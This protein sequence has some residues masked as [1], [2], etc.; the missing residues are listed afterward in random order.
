MAD[1][2][3]IADVG[4][5]LVQLLR[6]NMTPDPIPNPE[7]IGLASPADKGDLALSLFLYEVQQ[8]GIHQQN[9]WSDSGKSQQ[10]PPMA[11][12]LHF[13]LTAHSGADLQTRALDEHRILG[14]AIQVLYDNQT[15][16]GSWLQGALGDSDE[17]FRLVLMEP[18][19]LHTAIT[20][21]PNLPYKLS[22]NFIAG[23]IYLDSGRHKQ[24]QRVL[25]RK[26]SV[27]GL[28]GS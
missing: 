21:F 26:D 22:F 9:F 2:T 19:S 4:R 11:L 13:L 5:T 23:P 15:V 1:Y 3:A 27:R 14:R 7:M 6:A 8:N 16:R 28:E 25:D 18:L 24:V 17:E 12:D 10:A 20:L